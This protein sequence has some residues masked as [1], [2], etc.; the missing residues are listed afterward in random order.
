MG[1]GDKEV[2]FAS[3]WQVNVEKHSPQEAAAIAAKAFEKGIYPPKGVEIVGQW[4]TTQGRGI[5]I[6]K[7]EDPGAV[8][9]E[10]DVFGIEKSGFFKHQETFP[11]MNMAEH[12][13]GILSHKKAL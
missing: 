12:I 9:M 1:G 10:G 4:L 11:V 6:F 2:L 13:G 7:A 8:L 5:T 3:L